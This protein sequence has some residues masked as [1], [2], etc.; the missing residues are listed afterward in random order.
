MSDESALLAAIRDHPEEDTPRLVYADWLDEQGG[1][2][3]TTRA[4]FIRAQIELDRLP[5][6][7][8]DL[9]T[10]IR[11]AELGQR[12]EELS[13][14]NWSNWGAPVRAA[15]ASFGS[16]F[17]SI[18]LGGFVRGFPRLMFGG[19]A[20]F[21]TLGEKLFDLGPL[22]GLYGGVIATHALGRELA[23]P[24]LSAPGA[25]RIRRMSLM[26]APEVGDRLFQSEA[27]SGLVQLTVRHGRL[28][29]PGAPVAARPLTK[30]RSLCLSD[31]LVNGTADVDRLHEL[32][33]NTNLTELDVRNCSYGEQELARIGAFEQ[34][35]TLERFT[36]GARSGNQLL[37]VACIRAVTGAPFWA[38]LRS[39]QMGDVG[40]VSSGDAVADGLADAPPAPRLRRLD[41]SPCRLTSHGLAKLAANPI[42]STV[43]T[44]DLSCAHMGDEGA[45]I[46]AKSPYL[47]NLH[48]LELAV[49]SIGPKGVQAIADAPWS[50]GLVRM[51]L[52]DNAIRQ[53]GVQLLADPKHFPNLRRLDLQRCVRTKKLQAVLTA[54]YGAGVRFWF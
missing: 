3:N 48:H 27:L 22:H 52:R 35:R 28:A 4:E 47:M 42:L 18:M 31:V 17:N 23:D 30:L 45:R 8:D 1:P 25:A 36:L 26:V 34:C 6:E 51:N 11:R 54:R 46:L 49:S 41:L 24:F 29:A 40:E 20:Q 15:V 37:D 43:T 2:A 53:P 50:R 21:L 7:D 38:N 5:R 13:R 44:L 14:A 16:E 12:V 33:P 39:L 32:L 19:P 9:D 10:A